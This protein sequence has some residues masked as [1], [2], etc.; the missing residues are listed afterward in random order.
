VANGSI[1]IHVCIHGTANTF[2]YTYMNIPKFPQPATIALA[3][4]AT[5]LVNI[6]NDDDDDVY[7]DRLYKKTESQIEIEKT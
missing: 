6:C 3:V 4:P 7:L 1:Y 2:L 5:S